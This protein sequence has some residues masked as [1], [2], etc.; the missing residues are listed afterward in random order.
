MWVSVFVSL[1]SDSSE[2]IEVIISSVTASDSRMHD[3]FIIWT[4][5]FIQGH[6]ELNHEDSN[7]SIISQTVEAIPIMLAVEIARLKVYQSFSQSDDLDLHLR[8][9]VRLKR[10]K[11]IIL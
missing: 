3:V 2:A 7:C 5:T 4:L 6:T 9:Q 10:D 8:L 11:L 1:A